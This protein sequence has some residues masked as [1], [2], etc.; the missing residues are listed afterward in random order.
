[1]LN[2][3]VFPKNIWGPCA[4]YLLHCISIGDYHEVKESYKNYYLKFYSSFGYVL[5][6]IICAEHYKNI[7]GIFHKINMKIF[8]REYIIKWV[9]DF[10]N[11]V[12][13]NL[14]KKEFTF[15]EFTDMYLMTNKIDNNKIFFF[16]DNVFLNADYHEMSMYKYEQYHTFFVSLAKLYPDK[17]IRMILKKLIK[18]ET[19]KKIDTP[20]EFGIWY[21]RNYKK[22]SLITNI[23]KI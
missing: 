15:N 22:W 20:L 14:G 9:F 19:F 18:S 17:K 10:H 13:K 2:E 6:C 12:N 16:V 7:T 1:M 5:P 11:I 3:N 21:N 23:K 8:S 4:W